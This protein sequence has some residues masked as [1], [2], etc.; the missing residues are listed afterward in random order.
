MA[1]VEVAREEVEMAA[2]SEGVEL[3]ALE[4]RASASCLC[5]RFR[6]VSDT[7][8]PAG[9]GECP[10]NQAALEGVERFAGL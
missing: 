8:R 2:R 9:P 5:G 10:V 3:D 1:R 4:P 6:L 7:V